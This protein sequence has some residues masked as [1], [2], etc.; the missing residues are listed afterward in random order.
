LG[1]VSYYIGATPDLY[2]TKKIEY[3]DVPMS[4]FQTDIYNYFESEEERIARSSKIKGSKSQT[5]MSYTRQACNFVFPQVNQWVTSEGR[6][7]PGKYSIDEKDN[8]RLSRGKSASLKLEENKQKAE[9]VKKYLRELEKYMVAFDRYLDEMNEEDIKKKHTLK[10]D[11]ELYKTKYNNNYGDF[12]KNHKTKSKLYTALYDC[13]GKFTYSI[14][15]ILKSK[16]PVL[17]YSNYVLVEGLQIFKIYLKHFG[18]SSFINNKEGTNGFR[19]VEFHGGIDSDQRS[20]NID[21]YNHKNNITG[22]LVKIIMISPAGAEGLSLL[23]TRQVHLLEPYWNE[24]RMTQMIGRAIRQCSHKDLPLNERVVDV[25]R[26]KSVKKTTNKWTADQ[27][28][29]NLARGKEGIIESFCDAV[30]EAAVD[31]ELFKAHNMMSQEY[32]CFQFEEQSLF[33]DNKSES[34]EDKCRETIIGRW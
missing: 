3:I 28:I 8:D 16:G 32:K 1:L 26:Y 14:F 4:E 29:E 10:D 30:K 5:Y 25:Y 15:N 6:P 33:D 21:N 18:F 12:I 19:Y 22:E 31:C 23:N 2:A 17:V 27:I 9:N 7:R 24:V 11:I 20:I 34:I 13:S